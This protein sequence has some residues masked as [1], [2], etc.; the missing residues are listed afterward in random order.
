MTLGLYKGKQ[1][2]KVSFNTLIGVDL[3]IKFT[4]EDNKE[5]GA[6]PFL[7][8]IVKPGADG[9]L[10]I[11]VYRKPTHTEQYLW[12]NSHHHFSSKYSAINT[13]THRAKTVCNN[14]ELLHKEM[15]HIRKV[16]TYCK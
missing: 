16:L 8:T 1:I 14:P 3:A 11:T 7:D 15:E 10:S 5:E 2:N 13:L 12:W 6:I 4:V 9:K